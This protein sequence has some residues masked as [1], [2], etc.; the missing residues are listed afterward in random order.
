MA[1]PARIMVIGD[2]R[3]ALRTVSRGLRPAGYRV[4]VAGQQAAP[5]SIRKYR[6]DLVLLDIREPP[7]EGFRLLSLI[8]RF[9]TVPVIVLA[10]RREGKYL[11]EA[12][13]LGADDFFTRPFNMPLLAAR[14]EAMLRLYRRRERG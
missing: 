10:A 8:R 13:G 7:A 9:S 12:L 14:I 6:P 1:G 2:E 11:E 4:V 3:E 5:A